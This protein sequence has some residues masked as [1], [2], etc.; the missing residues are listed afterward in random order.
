MAITNSPIFDVCGVSCDIAADQKYSCYLDILERFSLV[1]DCSLQRYS[2]VL[3]IRWDFKVHEYTESNK[4]ISRM[5]RKLKIRLQRWGKHKVSIE[6]IGYGW[7]RELERSKNQHYHLFLLLNG[8]KIR[9][10][11]NLNEWLKEYCARND[12]PHPYFPK[13]GYLLLRRGNDS[14]LN[15]AFKRAS[16]LAKT[17]GKGY[18]GKHCKNYGT[19]RI[20]RYSPA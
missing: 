7:V 12:L 18:K 14:D 8:H 11:A 4:V 13:N 19:S 20:I 3:F 15:Q 1:F 6:N 10:P 16:Y 9:H 17:R 2:R 5:L